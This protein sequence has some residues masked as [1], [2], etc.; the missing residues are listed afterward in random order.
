M[1]VPFA[2]IHFASMKPNDKIKSLLE[3][4]E[5][6][7]F[8]S[9]KIHSTIKQNT[10]THNHHHQDCLGYTRGLRQQVKIQVGHGA[11]ATPSLMIIDNNSTQSVILV[12][13]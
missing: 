11:L 5:V 4:M 6:H 2:K 9:H 12:Q 13:K 8:N 3:K 1:S 7:A 10:V